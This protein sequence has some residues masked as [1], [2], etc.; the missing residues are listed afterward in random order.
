[1]DKPESLGCK[2]DIADIAEVLRGQTVL[3]TGA[4]GFIGARL[5][6]RLLLECNAKPRV[7]LRSY[8][9]AARLAR[10]GI[11]RFEI[12]L[13][14]LEDSFAIDAAVAGAAIVFH[15]AYDPGN[16][17]SNVNGVRA[18][19][20]ACV[21]HA[22]KLVH[23][24]TISVYEPLQDGNLDENSPTVRAGLPYSENKLDVE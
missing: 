21:K 3:V 22:T 24:S 19:I 20:D 11:D 12:V 13:G 9:R 18:I 6:E 10:F 4:S 1:M 2:E 8:S 23:V 14:S 15:C 16:P 7:F 17:T 5:V